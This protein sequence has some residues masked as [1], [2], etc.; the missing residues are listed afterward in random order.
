MSGCAGIFYIIYKG[1]APVAE[2]GAVYLRQAPALE[3]AVGAPLTVQRDWFGCNVQVANDTGTAMITYT[4]SGP[5][6]S[7]KT[8]VWLTKANGKWAPEGARF[9]PANG[10]SGDV[11][12]GTIPK[13]RSFG[14]DWD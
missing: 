10:S 6:N 13:G 9:S 11:D 4:V 14:K 5:K 8:I 1:T 12:M 3:A 7:G 2:V